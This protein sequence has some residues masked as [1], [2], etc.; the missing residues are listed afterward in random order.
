MTEVSLILSDGPQGHISVTYHSFFD[1]SFQMV[2]GWSDSPMATRE[3][4]ILS[5]LRE[6]MESTGICIAFL[7]MICGSW[8]SYSSALWKDLVMIQESSAN[9]IVIY[10]DVVSLQ[11]LMRH[12]EQQLV[13]WKVWILNSQWDVDH[14]YGRVISWESHFFTPP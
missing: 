14:N 11:G 3:N 10:G 6:D 5:D 2:L 8:N 7:K 13:T 4:Q 1:A 12:I 9:V